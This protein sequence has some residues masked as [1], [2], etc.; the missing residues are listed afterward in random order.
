[1]ATQIILIFLLFSHGLFSQA[2]SPKSA[3]PPQVGDA[4]PEIAVETLLQAPQNAQATLKAL[5]GKVVV[6]E[7]WA[8][9]CGPCIP[10][11]DHLSKLAKK[12]EDRPVQIIAIT[13]EEQ[14]DVVRFLKHKPARMWVGLD[15]DN[16]VFG[17]FQPIT[18]PHTIVINRSGK[19]AAITSPK[20]V[21]E[22]V[23]EDLLAEKAIALPLKA[24]GYAK[25]ETEEAFEQMQMKLDSRTLFKAVFRPS[26]S[27]KGWGR[28]YPADDPQF[29]SRRFSGDGIWPLGLLASAYEIPASRFVDDAALP[30]SGYFI[31]VIVPEGKEHL[32]NP[33][34]QQLLQDGLNIR[35]DIETRE[36]EVMVLR[37]IEGMSTPLKPSQAEKP[38]YTFRGPK[39]T[40]IKQPVN[41][42]V[43]YL[44][45][46]TRKPLIDETGL[47]GEYD[48]SMDWVM[49]NKESLHEELRKL[50]LELVE[51]K[52]RVEM[53]VVRKA[54]K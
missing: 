39:L 5:Q 14:K 17:A 40:A 4:A 6:L 25:D 18:I 50:G 46:A 34:V 54:S 43:D 22:Q 30:Q 21:T 45:N 53:L 3:M 24:S 23:I 47:S 2:S 26:D 42:L 20:E 7:L 33:T 19:I 28:R 32:L 41:K 31:D 12:F 29:P 37:Q 49:G 48:F 51:G 52:R 35:V 15:G 27:T 44:S 10:A 8:T 36:M 11:M 1:M 16:S 9:W 38:Y 13:S